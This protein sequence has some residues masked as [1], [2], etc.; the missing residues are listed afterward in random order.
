MD[1]NINIK[2]PKFTN[3]NYI[4]T[5]TPEPINNISSQIIRPVPI[6]KSISPEPLLK[7]MRLI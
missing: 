2:L 7:R 3:S 1:E 5:I 6:S 4:K